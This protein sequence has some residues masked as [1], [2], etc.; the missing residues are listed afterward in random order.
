MLCGVSVV[1]AMWAKRYRD[2]HLQMIFAW[3]G[4]KGSQKRCHLR[5]SLSAFLD[6]EHNYIIG[7]VN[8]SRHSFP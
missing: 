4:R 8:P 1:T 7:T 6:G 2:T 5:K 3:G